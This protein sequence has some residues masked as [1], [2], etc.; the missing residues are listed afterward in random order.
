AYV[1]DRALF[2]P[3]ALR[4]RRRQ[5][6]GLAARGADP[7]PPGAHAIEAGEGGTQRSI[8]FVTSSYPS[9][10]LGRPV[11]LGLIED[12]QRRIGEELLFEHLG[13]RLTGVV[14]PLCALDPAGERLRV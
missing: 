8:G 2:T 13:Q 5:L 9:V 1:G 4:A 10:A 7:L 12:G 11:A 3:A 14:A 6:V